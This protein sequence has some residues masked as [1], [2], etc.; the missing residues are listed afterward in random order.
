MLHYENLR[1]DGTFSNITIRNVT[2]DAC[3]N[4]HAYMT[5]EGIIPPADKEPYLSESLE[6]KK[7]TLICMGEDEAKTIFCGVILDT[8]LRHA[9]GSYAIEIKAVSHSYLLDIAKESKSYQDIAMTYHQVIG[10]D[11][12]GRDALFIDCADERDMPIDTFLLKHQETCWAFIQRVASHHLYG[13]LPDMTQ[14]KPAFWV[15]MPEGRKVRQVLDAPD[16][17]VQQPHIAIGGNVLQCTLTNRL[18]HFDLGDPVVIRGREYRVHE[19]HARLDRHDSVMRFDYHLATEQGCFQPRLTNRSIQGLCLPGRVIDRR[20]DFV[21]VHLTTTDAAQEIDKATWFRLAAFYT[22]GSDRGWC[23]MPELGDMLD[24][25][26]PSDNE[27]D[28][29]LREAVVP[30][31]PSLAG[32]VNSLAKAGLNPYM[33]AAGRDKTASTIPETKYIDVP[34]GQSMLLNDDLV[35]LSS[36]DGFSTLTLTSGHADLT[37]ATLGLKLKTDG[38]LTLAGGNISI[39]SDETETVNLASS[40]SVMLLCGGSSIHLDHESG[41]ADFYATEVTW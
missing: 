29:F 19:I 20:K 13:L 9:G 24:L 38:D 6:D 33:P 16:Q 1:L 40:K 17:I 23:A 41:N 7:L 34:N 39:G 2:I 4:D 3:Y 36:K 35:H 5:I 25:Y 26:F 8:K 15:G 12:A 32:R 31:F 18:E 22:A 14:G 37:G 28:C 11:L 27:N 21:K 30:T 10:S